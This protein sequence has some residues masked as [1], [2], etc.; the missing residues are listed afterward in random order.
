MEHNKFALIISDMGRKEGNREGYV[1]LDAIRKT[2]KEIPF[3]IY[4]DSRKQE[5]VNETLKR[6]GQ[7]CTNS[8]A[9]LIDLVIKNLLN[10]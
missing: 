7:G 2:N 9:E 10:N 1:L 8:P 6:G 5:H 3:I 4:A